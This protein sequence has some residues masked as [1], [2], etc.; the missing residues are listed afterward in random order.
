MRYKVEWYYN[1]IQEWVDDLDRSFFTFSGAAKFAAKRMC[2]KY[3]VDN[4]RVVRIKDALVM[5]ELTKTYDFR[6]DKRVRLRVV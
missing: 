5:A 1:T 6:K 4:Y 2:H 3:S